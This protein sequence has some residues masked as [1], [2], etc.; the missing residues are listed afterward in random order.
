VGLDAIVDN[1]SWLVTGAGW[2]SFSDTLFRYVFTEDIYIYNDKATWD[3]NWY[4]IA[5][6]AF[7]PHNA[8]MEM[9]LSM[10]IGG[11]VLFCL[12]PIIIIRQLPNE[13]LL[14]LAPLWASAFLL[15]GFWFMLPVALPFMAIAF[16]ASMRPPERI[17]STTLAHYTPLRVR[18]VCA[19]LVAL[20]SLAIW[21]QYSTA[22]SAGK[23]ITA[24]QQRMPEPADSI[25]LRD[26]GRGNTHLWWI[27]LN[28]SQYVNQKVQSKTPTKEADVLWFN[29]ILGMVGQT[30]IKG[31]ANARLHGHY[32]FMH[33]DL[34]TLYNIPMWYQLQTDRLAHWKTVMI[35]GLQAI[36]TRGDMAFQYY[37][38]FSQRIKPTESAETNL[39][40]A[41]RVL[42]VSEEA[43]KNNP[44]DMTA[45]W[46]SGLAMLQKPETT[47]LGLKRLYKVLDD[48]DGWRYVP[49]D[50]LTR[51]KI[52][53]TRRN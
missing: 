17:P 49:I 29:E 52:N 8:F 23:L 32:L 26:H 20:F 16:A 43:L 40:L 22:N 11:L 3:P 34:I 48:F 5:G 45:L 50:P 1:P 9:L 41:E 39:A 31:D 19:L 25:T 13:R 18:M 38:F 24:I 33:N 37:N 51:E 15:N 36:P 14:I 42:A 7:H 35:D 46:F 4:M 6:S 44:E 53:F 21:V 27:A 12:L 28:I 10:G 2:G 47:K 30:I